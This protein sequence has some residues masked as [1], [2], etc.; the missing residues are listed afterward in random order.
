MAFAR[1]NTQESGS[2]SGDPPRRFATKLP[3]TMR[4]SDKQ[5]SEGITASCKRLHRRCL[6]ITWSSGMGSVVSALKIT[7]IPPGIGGAVGVTIVA[8]TSLMNALKT[9]PSFIL[10]KR[11]LEVAAAATST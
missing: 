11:C 6:Y 3:S 9:S 2:V 10:G 7:L 1:C 4:D 5:T 8:V